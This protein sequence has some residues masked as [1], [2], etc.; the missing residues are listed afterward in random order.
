M[1][2]VADRH[3]TQIAKETLRMSE[4]GARIAGGMSKAEAR[5]YLARQGWSAEA[6]ARLE[7]SAGQPRRSRE[8]RASR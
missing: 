6:I 1:T 8:R 7:A 4:A 5:A 2:S 3:Q